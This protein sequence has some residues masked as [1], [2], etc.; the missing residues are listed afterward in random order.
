M[1][2]PSAQE[3]VPSVTARLKIWMIEISIQVIAFCLLILW[4]GH[5]DRPIGLSD[6]V[7][8]CYAVL[9]VFGI[10]GYLVTTLL[11]RVF[12]MQ[13]DLWLSSALAMALFLI[14]FEVLNR[15]ILPGGIAA[16]RERM[17][18]RLIGA[19]IT[20]ITPRLAWW[21]ALRQ[22]TEKSIPSAFRG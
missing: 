8:G 2:M 13:Q 5:D 21:I 14:H 22:R 17:L 11:A 7:V 1:D 3:K 10:S 19:C 12:L 15:L 4:I 18:I 16:P 20:F 6:I 9:Y